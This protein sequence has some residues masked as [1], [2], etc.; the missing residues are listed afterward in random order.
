MVEILR[1]S[2][3]NKSGTDLHRHSQLPT[4]NSKLADKFQFTDRTEQLPLF[5][6]SPLRGAGGMG[7]YFTVRLILAMRPLAVRTATVALPFL[8]ALTWPVVLLTLTTVLSLLFHCRV[9]LT[10]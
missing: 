5:K 6:K 3:K 1:I 4:P 8:R 9:V 2:N 7:A 10:L